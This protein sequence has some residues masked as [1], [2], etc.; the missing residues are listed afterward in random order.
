MRKPLVSVVIVTY[1]GESIVLRCLESVLN[2][3]YRPIEVIVVDNAS[4]DGTRQL[5]SERSQSWDQV[6]IIENP[7]NLGYAGGNNMGV[8]ES[9]GEYIILLNDDTVVTRDW[10]EPIVSVFEA[11]RTVAA[12]QP[13]L[14]LLDEPELLD[15]I[16]ASPTWTGF[17]RH[18]GVRAPAAT[19]GLNPR[20]IFSGKG[21][22]LAL[23]RKTLDSV[24]L[25]DESYF[26]YFEENDLCWRIWLAGSRVLYIP[27]STVYHQGA[28]TWSKNPEWN[29]VR[30]ELAFKN[31]F[32]M[33]LSNLGWPLIFF[34]L[35]I[36]FFVIGLIGID[37]ALKGRRDLNRR[38]V[39]GLLGAI[40]ELDLILSK[41]QRTQRLR[42]VPDRILTRNHFETFPIEIGRRGLF[43]YTSGKR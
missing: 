42:K 34:V 41:R 32:K 40:Q 9:R 30:F 17:L 22:A 31:R 20:E 25:L 38:L 19:R 43:Q 3:D 27:S 33:L 13:R 24:G 21:A 6:R 15:E 37:L 29:L 39:R 4:T 14:L 12:I 1:N 8:R 35:S 26:A 2:S 23:R 10:I 5:L 7:E 18:T 28:A 11:D 16:G 36:H